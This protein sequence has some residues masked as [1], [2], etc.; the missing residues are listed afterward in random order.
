MAGS[1]E[2]WSVQLPLSQTVA[3]FSLCTTLCK[4][5]LAFL[6]PALHQHFVSMR[7]SQ[8]ANKM[9]TKCSQNFVSVTEK[10]WNQFA[11]FSPK[12]PGLL[13]IL[14]PFWL[15]KKLVPTTRDR[16]LDIAQ[17]LLMISSRWLNNELTTI[18][19]WHSSVLLSSCQHTDLPSEKV[20]DISNPTF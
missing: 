7:C 5:Y 11:N 6:T 20:R 3:N 16:L 10:R 4:L 14:T 19:D 13:G 8:R 12:N 18:I 2:K 9:F 1:E 15:S 17:T